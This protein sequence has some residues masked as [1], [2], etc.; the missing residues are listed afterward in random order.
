MTEILRRKKLTKAV[1]IC[2]EDGKTGKEF[3]LTALSSSRQ[4]KNLSAC[5][6][7]SVSAGWRMV[8]IYLAHALLHGSSCLPSGIGRAA[9]KRRFTWHYSTQGLPGNCI[10]AKTR[11]LLPHVFTLIR[12]LADGNF[13]WHYLLIPPEAKQDRPLTGVLPC[14][15]RT[16]LPPPV[17]ES[18]NPA[19]RGQR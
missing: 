9:L 12:Q 5:K 14:A 16:F 10:T 11:E 2:R 17:A 18:D 13:L 7:D 1:S 19:D 15:V 6:P 4:E 8:I 3:G